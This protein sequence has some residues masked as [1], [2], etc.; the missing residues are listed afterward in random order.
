MHTARR[1]WFSRC[2][3]LALACAFCVA[4][5]GPTTFGPTTLTDPPLNVTDTDREISALAFITYAG[6]E[7]TY[8]DA[9]V[10]DVLKPC[11]EEQ[12]QS[13]PLTQGRY[14][15][16]WGPVVSRFPLAEYDDNMMYVVEDLRDPGRIVVALRGTNPKGLLDWL[17]ED[18]W[19]TRKE[20]WAWGAD[21]MPGSVSMGTA[22]GLNA[23]INMRDRD[24]R[25]VP[26]LL[27]DRARKHELHTIHITG[28]SLAGALAPVFGLWLKDTQTRWGEG[29][30]VAIQVTAL[31]GATPRDAE[32]AAYYDKRL[33]PQ[34]RRLH[35]P[36]DVVPLAWQQDNL[37]SIPGL[38]LPWNTRFSIA[39]EE[40]VGVGLLLSKNKRYTQIN[41]GQA[42][43]TAGFSACPGDALGQIAWQ[44][45]CGY[46][47]AMQMADVMLPVPARCEATPPPVAAKNQ[48]TCADTS[49]LCP[50]CPVESSL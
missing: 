30:E 31:A 22:V 24:W 28:H 12:L 13:H 26:A 48:G 15:L 49:R 40:L 47:C 7:L 27:R 50:V 19:V 45:H 44:H 34:T 9:V 39:E 11:V 41:Q 32:F 17:V 10:D 36:L 6:D 2:T 1:G 35:N 4:C 14:Q 42:S 16:I 25:D 38:Y 18:F 3:V 29:E 8:P 33:G 20:P 46:Y 21:A 43:L 5:V 37:R 23:L